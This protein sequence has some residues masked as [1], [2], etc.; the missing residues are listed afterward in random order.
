METTSTTIPPK[1]RSLLSLI[2]KS[3]GIGTTLSTTSVNDYH[4][5]SSTYTAF[6][7]DSLIE[8]APCPCEPIT[9]Q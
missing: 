5:V 9:Q 1:L 8:S 4:F 6:L 2:I 7:T 3:S